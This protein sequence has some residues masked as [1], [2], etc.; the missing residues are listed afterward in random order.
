MELYHQIAVRF[1]EMKSGDDDYLSDADFTLFLE[2]RFSLTRYKEFKS[3]AFDLHMV[4]TEPSEPEKYLKVAIAMLN[5]IN[6]TPEWGE[7]VKLEPRE[8]RYHLDLSG[9][10]YQI[11]VFS[12][13]QPWMYQGVLGKLDLVSLDLSRSVINNIWEL[14]RLK[15]LKTLILLDVD[16][17]GGDVNFFTMLRALPVQQVV[18]RRGA[19]KSK[20]IEQL[21]STGKEVT[22]LAPGETWTGE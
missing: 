6:D 17:V 11:Y 1:G 2:H 12:H 4:K 7:H 19:H 3:L 18:L 21:C 13:M 16:P 8:G 10:P 5:V 14:Q 22:L 15:Q 20:F 9:S